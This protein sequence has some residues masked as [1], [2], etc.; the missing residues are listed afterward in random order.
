MTSDITPPPPL[1]DPSGAFDLDHV[2]AVTPF[3]RHFD[4]KNPTTKKVVAVLHY[5]GGQSL[6]TESDYDTIRTFI[7]GR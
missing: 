5:V 4:P 1:I 6:Q 3:V 2:V 7:F